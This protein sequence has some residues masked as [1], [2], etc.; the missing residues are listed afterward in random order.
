MGSEASEDEGNRGCHAVLVTKHSTFHGLNTAVY[1][2]LTQY[3]TEAWPVQSF[4]SVGYRK[5]LKITR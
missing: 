2:P 5:G 4:G 3:F 1:L